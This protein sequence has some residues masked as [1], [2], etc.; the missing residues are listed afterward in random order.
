MQYSRAF[1]LH[2]T[3]FKIIKEKLNAWLILCKAKNNFTLSFRK[4]QIKCDSMIFPTNY[5]Q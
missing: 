2:D 4:I 3:L 5:T 1:M